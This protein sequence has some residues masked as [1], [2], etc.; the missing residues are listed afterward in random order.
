MFNEREALRLRLEQ[1]NDKE[2]IVIRELREERE[3]IYSKLRELDK[4]QSNPPQAKE[5]TSLMDLV[6]AASQK[7]KQSKSSSPHIQTNTAS[8]A[9]NKS[10][11]STQREAALKILN[12]HKEGIR[13]ASLRNE[14]EKETG[15]KVK[16]M[17]AFMSGLMKHHPEVKKPGRG[18]YIIKHEKSFE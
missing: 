8:Q 2:I 5:S 12:I 14:I 15:M 6:S 16:N 7:L 18:H 3:G 11:T 13:G 1:L 9:F 10:I 17:T 4:K